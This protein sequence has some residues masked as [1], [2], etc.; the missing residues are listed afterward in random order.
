MKLSKLESF[1][2]IV[3][4]IHDNPDADAVGSGF[5]LYTYFKEKGKQVRLVY[6]GRIRIE[7]SNMRMLI[8][9]LAIPVEYIPL[10]AVRDI[11]PIELLLTVDC[12]YGEGNVTRLEA[13]HVACIDHHSTGRASDEMAEI[14]SHL[15]SCATICYDMLLQAGFDINAHEDVATGLYYGLF[16]DSN[17]L[18][19][20]RHPLERDMVDFLKVDKILLNRLTHANFTLQELETAGIAMLRYSYDEAKRV[21]IVRSKP[22]DPNILGL[23]GDFIIQVDSIDVC[24]IFSETPGGY[25]LSVRSCVPDVTANDMAAYLTEKIGNGGGHLDKAGGYISEAKYGEVYGELSIESYF[26]GRVDK[27]YGSYEVIDTRDGVGSLEKFSL[28][29]K[30]PYS[31]GFVK[32]TDI[33]EAGISCKVRNYEG[34]VFVDTDENIYLLIGLYG[35]VSP[36]EKEKFEQLYQESGKKFEHAFDYVPSIISLR[37]NK[38]LD[39]MPYARECISK[40][41][42]RIWVKRLI[43]PA[44]VISRSDYEKNIYGRAGDYLCFPEN[45]KQGIYI[46]KRE[47]F[48]ELYQKAEN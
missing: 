4:Q 2:Q 7:K 25:K 5:A 39:I 35:E 16:M 3:I 45:D 20:I 18:A 30:K 29:E 31:Y 9:E 46:I 1:D 13:Q 15:V 34:D 42:P 44:R 33:F 6:S 24:V 23:I 47:L 32:T 43:S 48:G 26:F 41:G 21:S 10:K 14:R 27:Y 11:E 8:R 12:Q 36:I 17:Q 22:C 40:K 37:E 19:E 38:M 28:Y